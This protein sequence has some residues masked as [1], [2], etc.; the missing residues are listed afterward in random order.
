MKNEIL[1][2]ELIYTAIVLAVISVTSC[3]TIPDIVVPPVTPTTTTTTTIPPTPQPAET[4]ST[5]NAEKLHEH[6]YST[7]GCTIIKSRESGFVCNPNASSGH[8]K[9][10]LPGK[11]SGTVVK[12]G[13]CVF[14]AD[15]SSRDDLHRKE[16]NEYPAG[17]GPR[18]RYEGTL[19]PGAYPKNLWI[20]W[21][22]NVDGVARDYAFC[23][24]DPAARLGISL[25][26]SV[27]K[28]D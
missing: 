7:E 10:I 8:A 12:G 20:R 27:R 3:I 16:P 9:F 5:P 1:R 14:S 25:L 28:D 13:V 22:C 17:G 4:D 6:V 24:P 18:Q 26:Q 21:N 15:G 2:G 19:A 11:Y 23:V